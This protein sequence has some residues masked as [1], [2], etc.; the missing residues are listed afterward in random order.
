MNH[1]R[2]YES[3]DRQPVHENQIKL[4]VRNG[5]LIIE[6]CTLLKLF[7]MFKSSEITSDECIELFKD[8]TGLLEL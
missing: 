3:K 8:R 4:A 2:N 5:S 7:E 1:Q 6:S